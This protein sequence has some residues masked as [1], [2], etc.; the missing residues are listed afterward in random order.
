LEFVEHLMKWEYQLTL[1]GLNNPKEAQ[2][3]LNRLGRDGWE[4][5]SI[6]SNV[7]KEG[8]WH[9]ASLRRELPESQV[10]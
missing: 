8:S 4:L 1:L 9:I 7:G 10:H 6:A 2:D 3:I 5:V